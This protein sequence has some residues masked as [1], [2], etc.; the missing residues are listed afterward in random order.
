M[1]I[2]IAQYNGSNTSMSNEKNGFK[3]FERKKNLVRTG[4]YMTICTTPWIN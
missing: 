4:G 2:I 3:F 1:Y